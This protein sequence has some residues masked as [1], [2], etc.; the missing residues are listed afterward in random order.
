MPL[1]AVGA[2]TRAVE[3]D[4]GGRV[5][6]LQPESDTDGPRIPLNRGKTRITGLGL[7][8]RHARLGDLHALGNVRLPEPR[9]LS[10]S[11]KFIENPLDVLSVF[12]LMHEFRVS[13]KEGGE[14]T[15]ISH[16]KSPLT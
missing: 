2:R 12:Q 1:P 10:M 3:R 15:L 4:M 16:V 9:R 8:V 7:E 11:N 14:E 5:L 6:D 13:L